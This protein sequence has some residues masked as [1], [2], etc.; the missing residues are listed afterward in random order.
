AF[1]RWELVERTG[2]SATWAL[3]LPAAYGYPF[4]VR[5]VTTYA[6]DAD[7][8][9]SVTVEGTAV[10]PSAAPFGAST[11]PYLTCDGRPLDECRVSLPAASVLLTDDRGTPTRLVPVAEA[12][13]DL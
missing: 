11:H 12:D 13:L 5:C 4:Q 3:E 2:S 7:S 6:L 9:L 10:G 1:Q 8:G